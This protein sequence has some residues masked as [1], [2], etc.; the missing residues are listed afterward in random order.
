[1]TCDRPV[2]PVASPESAAGPPREPLSRPDPDGADP[3]GADPDGADPDG[4]D[5]D[6]AD[7]DGSPNLLSHA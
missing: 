6:G 5:P 1:V 2:D 7:P 4:A 3:D